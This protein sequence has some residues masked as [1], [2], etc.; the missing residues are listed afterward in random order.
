MGRLIRYSIG[1]WY[2]A[3]LPF[4]LIFQ[5]SVLAADRESFLARDAL[6]IQE[7]LERDVS[8]IQ[9][10]IHQ[11][12]RLGHEW[13]DTY[14]TIRADLENHKAVS[15]TD[16]VLRWNALERTGQRTGPATLATRNAHALRSDIALHALQPKRL[17][18]DMERAELLA[19]ELLLELEAL[20]RIE[21]FRRSGLTV[22]IRDAAG[23]L[24][25]NAKVSIKQ[26]DHAFLFGCNVFGWR[27]ENTP[28]QKLYRQRFAQL[29][30]FATL[31]YYWANY[32]SQEGK[33]RE[34]HWKNVARWCAANGI[35]TKGHPL[36]W[37]FSDPRWL[38]NDPDRN[39]RLQLDR[40]TREVD[41]FTGQVDIWDV[42]NETVKFDRKS[43]IERSPK[44]TA[45]WEKYGQFAFPIQ[46]FHTARK[47]N[48]DAFLLINDYELS[49][50]KGDSVIYEDVIDALVDDNGKRLYDAIGIQSHMHGG[51][52]TTER[53]LKIARR[54][55]R[56][57]VPLHFTETT[58]VSGPGKWENWR[59]TTPEG[60]RVQAEEIERLY[61]TIFSCPEIEALTWWDFSDYRSWQRAPSGLVR[62]DMSPKPAYH[63]LQ[64]LI[65]GEWWTLD[66]RRTG[67]EGTAGF[68]GFLGDYSI[69][70][71]SPSGKHTT[72][73]FQLIKRDSP[74]TVTITL[75]P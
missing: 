18:E 11:K 36:A 31:G 58:L 7:N 8:L 33:T 9:P 1:Y 67:E 52:W 4:I 57:G 24:L 54:F 39:Y 51:P 62:K 71:T 3:V 66:S 42:V 29:M 25:P 32:E 64:S 30:N 74:E 21:R 12:I 40:I 35:K 73:T 41:R 2:I 47:A 23:K 6:K 55:G 49:L 45:M 75:D 72:Q 22:R 27:D 60:E 10:V 38:P 65:H 59:E 16:W 13:L 17:Q 43:F 61:R 46:A 44:L 19:R 5:H 48:P 28:R 20:D 14:E 34:D 26:T 37:N 50:R 56:Y 69:T 15:V 68:R 63:R 53:I 70:A